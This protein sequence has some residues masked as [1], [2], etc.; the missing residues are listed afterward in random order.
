MT[1]ATPM[2]RWYVAQTHSREEKKAL[3]HLLRQGFSA[4]L[5]Q[6]LKRRRHARKTETVRSPLFPGYLFIN[7]DLAKVRW[8]AVRSTVGIRALLCHGDT[9]VALPEAVIE[10]IRAREDE[11][12][13]VPIRQ[14]APFKKGE[15][16]QVTEGPLKDQVG[17]FE[18]LSDD[19]RV[20]VLLNLLG[21]DMRVT[22]PTG[23]V[24]AYL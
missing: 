11:T 16:V 20:V 6:Y 12:G 17:W 23:A 3:A 7:M 19:E 15:S 4:Y 21:R 24:A 2:N 9:P 13:L 5:P 14:A 18:A 10:D 1:D 8:R 22:L